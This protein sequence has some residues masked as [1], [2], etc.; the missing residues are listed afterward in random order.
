MG[1]RAIA[2][3]AA[4]LLAAAACSSGE[5]KRGVGDKCLHSSDCADAICHAGICVSR[6]P[7]QNGAACASDAEC[8]SLR[9]RGGVCV[10]GVRADGEICLYDEECASSACVSELCGGT[11]PDTGPA[12]DAG[13]DLPAADAELPPD[14]ALPPDVGPPD[15]AWPDAPV[16]DAAGP[17]AGKCYLDAKGDGTG[18]PVRWPS[19]PIE[20]KINAAR[21][22]AGLTK[23]AVI[24]AIK[25]AFTT[26]DGLACTD[27]TFSYAGESTSYSWESGVIL[28]YIGDDATTWPHGAVP[29]FVN[30]KWGS[31]STG[32][33]SYGS[34][35]VNEKDFDWTVGAAAGKIDI[36][37][38][39]HLLM[40]QM[41]GFFVGTKLKPPTVPLAYNG[42]N[43]QLTADHVDAARFSYFKAGSGCTKP[44]VAPCAAF[45]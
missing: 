16:P 25:S 18:V 42:V 21:L 10:P 14:T 33:I 45:P 37:S 8:R 22:P 29:Y 32:G 23:A 17:F 34:I 35:G 30:M 3:L 40:P 31:A 11:L 27:V 26:W 6:H 44:K 43:H 9:C 4:V 15:Q 13:P 24:T 2:L 12:P 1:P 41:L 28:V 38:A 19:T 36:Q 39:V 5:E 20:Y 7:L